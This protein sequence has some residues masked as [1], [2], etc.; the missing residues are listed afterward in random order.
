MRPMLPNKPIGDSIAPDFRLSS[1]LIYLYRARNLVETFNRIKQCRRVGSRHYK[2]VANYLAFIEPASIRL[3]LS[4][5]ESTPRPPLLFSAHW[6]DNRGNSL[7]D[8]L[9]GQSTCR[10]D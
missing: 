9:C 8:A 5:N 4:V 2:F 7:F 1:K 3:W 6:L 10:Q